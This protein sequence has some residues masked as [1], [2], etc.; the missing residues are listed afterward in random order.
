MAARKKKPAAVREPIQVYLDT[1]ERRQLDQLAKQLDVS[2]AEVL[3]RGL[4]A[5]RTQKPQTIY[6]AFEPLIGSIDD[7]DGPTD[8]AENHDKYLADWREAKW[9][10]G[11]SS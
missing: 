4:D 7:P 1:T 2:R 8:M 9:K 11:R 10:R 3:R 5:L 6:E